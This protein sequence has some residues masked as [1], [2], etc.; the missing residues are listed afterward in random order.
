MDFKKRPQR[1]KFSEFVPLIKGE[2]KN[3]S[4]ESLIEKMRLSETPQEFQRRLDFVAHEAVK[5]GNTKALIV[6]EN[7]GANINTVPEE[8]VEYINSELNYEMIEF[9]KKRGVKV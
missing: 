9:L 7:Y 1:V 5:I 4:L 3:I 8:Y 6:L 2:R